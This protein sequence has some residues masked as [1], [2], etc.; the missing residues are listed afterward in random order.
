LDQI[1]LCEAEV[2]RQIAAARQ[3][4][5]QNVVKARSEANSLKNEFKERG[6]RKG[7]AQYQEIISGA[8]DEAEAILAQ[9]Q[10]GAQAMLQHGQRGMQEAVNRAVKIVL[11]IQSSSL[12]S[13]DLR[14][15]EGSQ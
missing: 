12:R 1:R 6:L 3:A 4:A 8:E 11:G 10:Q 15:G 5:E 14:E 2:T 13:G 7:Q 9:A